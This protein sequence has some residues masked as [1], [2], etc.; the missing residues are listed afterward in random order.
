MAKKNNTAK[1]A[2]SNLRDS[3]IEN[4]LAYMSAAVIGISVITMIVTLIAVGLGFKGLPVVL[5]LVP[6]IGFPIGF[7]LVFT[8]LLINLVRRSRENRK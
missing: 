1:S 7:V 3:R 2:P 6:V 5:G 4:V 8:L